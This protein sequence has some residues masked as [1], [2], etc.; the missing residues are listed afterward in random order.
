VREA[1]A[2]SLRLN[3]VNKLEM[4]PQDRFEAAWQRTVLGWGTTTEIATETNVS[5]RL[6]GYM[7]EV[8]Q[9]YQADDQ[10]GMKLRSL[11]GNLGENTWSAARSACLGLATGAE[12]SLEERAATLAHQLTNKMTDFLSRDPEVTA[13]ALKLYDRDLPEP[14]V[15]YLKQHVTLIGDDDG[16]D[17]P[18][19]SGLTL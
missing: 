4:S 11:L 14:L 16:E 19:T 15:G 17:P 3:E 9:V 12:R 13:L 8:R 6:A 2:E 18:T 10:R 1:V 5:R 7:R